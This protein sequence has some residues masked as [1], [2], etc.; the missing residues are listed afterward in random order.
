MEISIAYQLFVSGASALMG[1]FLGA[2]YDIV[3]ISRAIFGIRYVNKFTYHL[4]EIKLPLIKNPLLIERKRNKV[5]SN[6]FIFVT[7]IIYFLVITLIMMVFVYYINDGIVRWYIFAGAFLGML[8]YYFTVGKL[9]IS[10]SEYI[11]FFIKT[12]L[13]YLTWIFLWIISPALRFLK[14]IFSKIKQKLSTVKSK[15]NKTKKGLKI[16]ENIYK[17]GKNAN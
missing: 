1:L 13:S 11:V 9:V 16:K 10:V 6:I 3:R 5:L 12:T 7:D 15:T 2:I 14:G 8:L 17:I 4:K